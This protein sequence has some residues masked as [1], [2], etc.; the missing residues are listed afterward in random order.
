MTLPQI[1]LNHLHHL[2]SKGGIGTP[3]YQGSIQRLVE[4]ACQEANIYK[5]SGVDAVMIENMH[6]I[7]Y[8]RSKELGPEIV[9]AMTRVTTEVKKVIPHIP[10]GIQILAGGNKEALSIAKACDLQ[11]IRVE[12]FV[13]SHIG[14]EGFIDA[15]AGSLLRYRR[16]IDA[17]SVLIFSDIK[18][19]HSSHQITSDINI[20]E[21][22]LAA[23]FFLSDA[24]VIS[25][26]TTGSPVNQDELK[27]TKSAVEIPVIVGSGVT[28]NN[29]ECYVEAD[30]F[31]V[32]SHF[33]KYGKWENDIFEE[34][35]KL[36]MEKI[37]NLRKTT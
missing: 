22:A 29:M 26:S 31:I 35:V 17:E 9:S 30:A 5:N 32:G 3:R 10:C 34:N 12:G 28:I 21:T 14:D 6:D 2:S 1:I 37:N 15:S 7:P 16:F 25:G 20:V 4:N 19:K 11:F 13:F 23:Q 33:K 27:E 36:F 24:V 18:K 8:V